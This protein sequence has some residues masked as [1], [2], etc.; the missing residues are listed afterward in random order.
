LTAQDV[1]RLQLIKRYVGIVGLF[2]EIGLWIPGVNV[3]LSES[4]W[5]LS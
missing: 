4:V 2:L 3:S 5:G 1:C